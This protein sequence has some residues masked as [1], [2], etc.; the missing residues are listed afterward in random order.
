MRQR[1]NAAP[2]CAGSQQ[3]AAM[4]VHR[5]P[6][7]ESCQ[8]SGRVRRVIAQVCTLDGLLMSDGGDCHHRLELSDARSV[9][10]QTAA[11]GVA[12]TRATAA[13]AGTKGRVGLCWFWR[14]QEE[15]H[16]RCG[17]AAHSPL[18]QKKSHDRSI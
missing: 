15:Q 12:G 9:P 16:A 5:G 7:P 13:N 11:L 17:C 6:L 18:W 14:G 3:I 1:A 8:D 10:L 2:R 4:G